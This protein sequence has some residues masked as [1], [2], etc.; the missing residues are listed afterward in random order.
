MKQ[1]ASIEAACFIILYSF[2]SHPETHFLLSPARNLLKYKEDH[3]VFKSFDKFWRFFSFLPF[4]TVLLVPAN[5]KRRERNDTT[6]VL[7]P[8]G[9]NL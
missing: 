7:H 9:R 1:A 5:E 4:S 2:A 6:R 8:A 3:L